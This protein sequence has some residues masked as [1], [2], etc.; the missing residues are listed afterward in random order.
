MKKTLLLFFTVTTMFTQMLAAKLDLKSITSGQFRPESMASLK[1]MD[2]GESYTQ[3][4]SDGTKILKFSFRTGKQ[5]GVIFDL[6]SVRGPKIRID[7]ID[8]YIFSPDKRRILIQTDTR[9]VYRRSFTATY[10]IY[11][12]ENNRMGPLSVGGEQQTPL[13]SPDG[14]MIAFV[15]DNNIFLVKLLYDN[16]ESQVTTDGERNHIINGIPD[17]VYEEE[18]STNRSMVFSADSRQIVWIKYDESAVKE[19]SFPWFRG[20]NPSRDEYL[21][22]PGQYVYKYP[23]AGEDNSK[24]AV[25][26]FDIKSRQTRKLDIPLDADG[27]IPRIVMTSD[28]TKVAVFTM[29]RHQDDM[30]IYMANPLSTV[31]K[32]VVQD[33]VEKYVKQESM[34][35]VTFTDQHILVPSERDGYN[36]LY[37]Y[38]LNGQL[39]RSIAKGEKYEITDVYGMDDKTGDVY[40]A[41]NCLGPQD[42]QVYVSHANGKIERLTQR[43]GQ[44]N[45]VFSRGFRYFIN[46]WNDINNP[47]VY[48]LN[49]SRGKILHTMIDNRELKQKY[50]SYG[51]GTKELFSFTTSEGVKLNGWMV[52]PA[53]FDPSKRYPVI[54][55]Q[56]GGPGS[57]Q[58]LNSWN[59]GAAGQGAILEQYMAQQGY[60]VVCVDNRGT[61]GRGAEFEKC[62]YLRLGEK[63]AFDQVETALWL[64]AQPYVDKNRIGMWG[65]SYGGWN[66]LMSMSEGRPVFRAGV[67]VAPPTCWR[68]YDSIY[69]ER[70]MRTPKENAQGYDEVNPIAR[71]SKLHGSL[72]LCHG[73]ADD[74][75]HFQNC[76]EYSEALVQADK[77]FKENIYTNRNHGISGGNTRTHLYRQIIQW[78]DKEM[79]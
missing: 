64:G 37:V 59:I 29:N 66:T 30:R 18:F 69:T 57:Q 60:I 2:D 8:G 14:N 70:Y 20:S 67:A 65:W 35:A 56:Y 17:W 47:S 21:T 32:L 71:A 72:L 5:T 74:N 58:V 26:S 28:P 33:K 15:R 24:V 68:Y 7:R 4:S 77:D 54:M 42:K 76:A 16:A 27:Y 38:T 39:K 40:Y 13:F 36:H 44:N 45:A 10:Y 19:F 49:D 50:D 53:G 3:I 75:V 52:K 22:Y 41:A 11:E 63:E 12:V 9:Y 23:K 6:N 43:E 55:Y 61:G 62:T 51:F 46:V 78:F 31:S 1:P 48:T 34:C 25:Y 79:K 73:I